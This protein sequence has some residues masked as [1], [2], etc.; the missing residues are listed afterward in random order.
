MHAVRDLESGG[1]EVLTVS[2]VPEPELTAGG[3]LIEVAAAGLNRADVLQR[4]GHYPVPPDATDVFG[5]EVSGTVLELGEDVP[6][7]AGLSVG[8]PVVAL[9]DSG[10]YAERVLAPW[11][12]VLPLP[13]G[14]DPVA[15]AG[16]PEV[17]ATVFSNVFMA[18]AARE[19]ETLLVH[20]GA[21][22]I[23]THA[24]Q[25]ARALGMTVLATVGSEEK[26]RVVEELGAT[27]IRYRDE[28]FVARVEELTDGRG[29]DVILDVV[30]AKYVDPNLRAVATNGRIVII[31]MQGGATG[32]LNVGRLLQKRAA[33]IGTTL[34]ARP[35]AEK[36]AIMAAV[37]EHVWP[38]VA[39]GRVRPLVSRTFPLEQV[40]EAHEYFDSGSHVGKVLLSM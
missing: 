19:G 23:G 28:D 39:A 5:L 40:R 9:V 2:E 29:A 35:A 8:D 25:V 22:G 20:G 15:A 18:A 7:D 6:A 12:Q 14:V 16:L 24:I 37:R 26:A 31:G 11:P 36:A 34:R 13:E 27:P 17:A 1:P 4:Q 21:G 10:G 32:E 3:V 30:G 33:V 38:L